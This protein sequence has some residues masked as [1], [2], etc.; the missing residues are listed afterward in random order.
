VSTEAVL[1]HVIALELRL[2]EPETRRDRL[3][4]R[5]LLHPDFHEIGASGRT[6]DRDETVAALADDPG[7]RPTVGDVAA[8]RVADGVVLVTYTAGDSRRSSLWVRDADGWRVLFHQ[9]T[10]TGARA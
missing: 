4:V 7:E 10:P 6:W 3:L 8:R 9:G 1:D 5:S 2:L